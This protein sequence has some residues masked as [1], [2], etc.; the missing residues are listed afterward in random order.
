MKRNGETDRSK[1]RE[2]DSHD[3]LARRDYLDLESAIAPGSRSGQDLALPDELYDRI[4]QSVPLRIDDT[5]F[6]IELLSNCGAWQ[7]K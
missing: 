3:K 7:E 6:Q 1:R 2:V 4:G 5:P